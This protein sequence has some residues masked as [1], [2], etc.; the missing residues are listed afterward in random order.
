MNKDTKTNRR[1]I[2]QGILIAIR[3]SNNR[4]VAADLLW[5][6][7]T[8]V[9]VICGALYFSQTVA[10]LRRNVDMTYRICSS[11]D[12]VAS[13]RHCK[14]RVIG[15]GGLRVGARSQLVTASRIVGH[16]PRR[17]ARA[18]LAPQMPNQNGG[19]RNTNDQS[20]NTD[21]DVQSNCFHRCR[22]HR[23]IQQAAISC[24]LRSQHRPVGNSCRRCPIVA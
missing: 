2:L 16:N 22:R 21:A 7:R 15:V 11:R 4:L 19:N 12:I 13:V 3:R 24:C 1:Q 17:I 6:Q 5:C 23:R 20:A 14:S 18:P 8:V 9:I 10:V